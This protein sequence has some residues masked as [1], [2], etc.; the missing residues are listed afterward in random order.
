MKIKAKSIQSTTTTNNTNTCTNRGVINLSTASYCYFG[1]Y[2]FTPK[3]G[4]FKMGKD[5]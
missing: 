2:F 5:D 1:H 3:P 4:N